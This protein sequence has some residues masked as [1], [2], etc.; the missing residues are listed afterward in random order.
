M[1]IGFEIEVEDE[2]DVINDV[3]GITNVPEGSIRNGVEY[4]S[5]ILPDIPF[6][7]CM[8]KYMYN[9]IKGN[10]SE[11]CGFHFHMDF[12]DKGKDYILSFV[13]RYIMVERALFCK[14]HTSLRAS[15]LF[16]RPLLDSTSDLK[17]IRVYNT[18]SDKTR[19]E[20]NYSKYTALNLKPLVTLGTIE[21][22]ACVAGVLPE[23]FEEL[24]HIFEALRDPNLPLP[25][26]VT[27]EHALEAEAQI[28][29]LDLPISDGEEVIGEFMYS[30]FL[31]HSVRPIQED[32]VLNY[33]GET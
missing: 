16:C 2:D 19:L 14:F 8:Y 32:D 24:L 4:V 6:A 31:Q 5:H 18:D 30:N 27:T 15:N 3:P 9:R 22:R 29:L 17:D 26:E 23:V 1:R 10:M 28:A 12:T 20:R 13:K 21:F 7:V 25:F 33:L 11:R